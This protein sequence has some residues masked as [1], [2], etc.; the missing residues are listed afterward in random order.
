M[1]RSGRRPPKERSFA[2]HDQEDDDV[3]YSDDEREI[4]LDEIAGILSRNENPG[5]L[6]PEHKKK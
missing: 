4:Y 3:V 5:T 2:V 6:V 1:A